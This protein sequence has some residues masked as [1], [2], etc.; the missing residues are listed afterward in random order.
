MLESK[1]SEGRDQ[2]W[3]AEL[4]AR[5][6]PCSANSPSLLT[7]LVLWHQTL[8]RHLL[9]HPLTSGHHGTQPPQPD[10][11]Q[12]VSSLSRSL[13]HLISP[14]VVSLPCMRGERLRM[15]TDRGFPDSQEE[16]PGD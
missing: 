1:R 10:A 16:E 6:H 13:H 4:G 15:C 11:V 14:L 3:A 8:T 5:A 2:L 7:Q 12:P 9:T